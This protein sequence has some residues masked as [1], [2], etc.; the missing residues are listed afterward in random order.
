MLAPNHTDT[1]LFRYLVIQRQLV[2]FPSAFTI[3]LNFIKTGGDTE[4]LRKL[5][6]SIQ[7]DFKNG[8][9]PHL[10]PN[11][12]NTTYGPSSDQ[13]C[14]FVASHS[15]FNSLRDVDV[16]RILRERLILVHG[17][18]FD[19]SYGWD[20]ASFGRLYDVDKKT[21]IQG[22]I[23]IPFLMCILQTLL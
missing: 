13:S 11:A 4:T 8:L 7:A 6:Q 9:P 14:I 23:C 18:P 22:E 15:D 12:R 10:Q 1:Y 19:Y 5:E 2:M 21:T 3:H 16:Q 17:N 20:L